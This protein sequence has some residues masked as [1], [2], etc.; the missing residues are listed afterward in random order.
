MYHYLRQHPDVFMSPVKEPQYYWSEG[1]AD[2][3]ESVQTA[4]AYERLFA[5]VTTE[6]A[7]GEASVRMLHSPTAVER[8]FRDLPGV[9]LVASLR[10]PAHRAYSHHL[11]RMRVGEERRGAEEALVPGSPAF[12]TSFYAEALQRWLG[13]F[14][15]ERLHV[16]LYED[17]A[18]EPRRT[19]RDLFAFLDVDPSFAIDTSTVHNPAAAPRSQL[20]TAA[21]W[22]LIRA[23]RRILPAPLRDRGF[24]ARLARLTWRRADPMPPALRRRLL[25]AYRD[26]IAATGRLLGR[27]L[28]FWF[29]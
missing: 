2:Y 9:R 1:W 23:V 16:I 6:R 17:F 12:E 28:S 3:P 8:V 4:A 13:R 26:D 29:V 22:K 5:G 10:N 15:R 14:P 19:M 24:G 21:V 27:D 20:L 7:I 11:H 25:D 18:A